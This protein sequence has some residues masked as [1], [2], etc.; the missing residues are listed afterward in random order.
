MFE[1]QKSVKKPASV[2]GVGLHTGAPARLT[3]LPAPANSGLR[4]TRADLPGSPALPALVS[5]VQDTQRGTTLGQDGVSVH[6]VEHVLAALAGRGID[7]CLIELTGPEPPILDGSARDFAVALKDAGTENLNAKPNTFAPEAPVYYAKD[8]TT[9]VILP[10]DRLRISCSIHFPGQKLESQHYTL[11]ITDETFETELAPARTFCFY[12]EVKPLMDAGLIKGGSL[13][14]AVV[15]KD[16]E[17]LSKEALR[18]RDEFVRHK[19][20]DILGDVTLLGRPLAGHIVAVRPGHAA[21][22]ALTQKLFNIVNK[23]RG[24]RRYL[25]EGATYEQ[26]DIQELLATLPH[27]YPFI[28]VD[29]ILKIEETEI[30]GLKNVTINEPFFQGHFPGHPIMPGVLQVE[31]MAQVAGILMLRKGDSVGKLA[32]FM[33]A[34]KVKFRKPVTPGD[35]LFIEVALLKARAGRIGR[36]QAR[37]LVDNEVVSEAELM[38]SIMDRETT[39]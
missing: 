38:F 33:S 10:S 28:L 32:Y 19:M 36:A 4:F 22:V 29:R 11:D 31:A 2:E 35:T 12:E 26:M 27:R 3:F 20:L 5:L 9:L 24:A 39:E 21:N 18:F 7:N 15:I 8:G 1:H 16:D 37:C 17:I 6:T 14:C 30:V 25:A 34:D 13:E 23:K